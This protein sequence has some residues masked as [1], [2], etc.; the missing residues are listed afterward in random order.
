MSNDE[1]EAPDNEPRVIEIHHLTEGLILNYRFDGAAA[2][3]TFEAD[4]PFH[5]PRGQRTFAQVRLTNARDLEF[6][7]STTYFTSILRETF[8]LRDHRATY[9]IT[10]VRVEPERRLIL[11]FSSMGR[12]SVRFDSYAITSRTATQVH[13]NLYADVSTGEV[14][15]M[16]HPFDVLPGPPA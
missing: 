14:F 4:V 15:D 5:A 16:Y 11:A 10:L 2:T 8:Q 3:F 12:L 1:S 9:V 7:A 13:D 6:Q